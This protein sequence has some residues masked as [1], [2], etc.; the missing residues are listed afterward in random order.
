MRNIKL[1]WNNYRNKNKFLK[2]KK[3]QIKFFKKQMWK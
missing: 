2:L 3:N 1:Y